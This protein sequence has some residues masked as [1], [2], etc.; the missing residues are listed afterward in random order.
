[1]DE[2]VELAAVSPESP[3]G[4]SRVTAEDT[5]G[6]EELLSIDGDLEKSL[7]KK[8]RRSQNASAGEALRMDDLAGKLPTRKASESSMMSLGPD[9]GGTATDVSRVALSC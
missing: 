8:K 9:P 7:T 2:E 3:S 4:P 5:D 1:M 6:T